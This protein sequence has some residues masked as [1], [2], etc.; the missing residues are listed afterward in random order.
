ML[1]CPVEHRV[2]C[3]EA[4]PVAPGEGHGLLACEGQDNVHTQGWAC[5]LQIGSIHPSTDLERGTWGK[6]RGEVGRIK[7]V[8]KKKKAALKQGMIY[9]G[10]SQLYATALATMLILV[11]LSSWMNNEGILK[12]I[13]N[14]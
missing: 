9:H 3:P 4:E 6:T 8:S 2:I 14:E 1:L 11:L 13:I 7:L 12:E 10:I 5:R